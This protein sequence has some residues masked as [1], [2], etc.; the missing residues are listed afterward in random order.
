[1]DKAAFLEFVIEIV[2]R[3]EGE[4]GFKVLP[5]RWVVERTFGWLIQWRR[6]MRDYVQR[7]D[8]SEAMIHVAMGSFLLR[9]ISH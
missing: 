2:R 1:M 6:L 4:Q 7:I 9:R 3:I 8:V 5:R